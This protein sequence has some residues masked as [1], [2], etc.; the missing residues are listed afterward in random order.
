M[1]YSGHFRWFSWLVGLE[2]YMI[3]FHVFHFV[4]GLKSPLPGFKKRVGF[5]NELVCRIQKQLVRFIFY[6][7]EVAMVLIGGQY[8]EG[9]VRLKNYFRFC[10]ARSEVQLK[11]LVPA[12]F[13]KVFYCWRSVLGRALSRQRQVLR[14]YALR[15]IFFWACDRVKVWISIFDMQII[16]FLEFVFVTWRSNAC[17]FLWS[18]RRCTSSPSFPFMPKLLSSTNQFTWQNWWY[19]N[20]LIR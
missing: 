19:N 5:G 12:P 14:P 4:A 3:W 8:L 2:F 9:W 6:P 11:K 1:S 18:N 7:V 20:T 13:M 16:T 15:A 10:F 17:F